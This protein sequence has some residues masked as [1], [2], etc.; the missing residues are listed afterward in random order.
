[1]ID[2]V[3][4]YASSIVK[5]TINKDT[6]SKYWTNLSMNVDIRRAGQL[7]R[8]NNE[9]INT[10]LKKNNDKILGQEFQILEKQVEKYCTAFMPL[11][12]PSSAPV[13]C[14]IIPA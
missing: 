7:N 6:N 8:G 11:F 4:I 9:N 5:L 10:E 13:E 12:P 2:L 3:F 1:M 14:P